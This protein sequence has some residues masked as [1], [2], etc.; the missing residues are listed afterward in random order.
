MHQSVSRSRSRAALATQGRGRTSSALGS[1]SRG[2]AAL[3]SRGR[4]RAGAALRSLIGALV[5]GLLKLLVLVAA[6][7]SAALLGPAFVLDTPQ[8]APTR[9]DAIVVISGD[10][11]MARFQEGLNLYQQGLGRYLVFS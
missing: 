5:R 6:L 1:P 8:A 2:R 10:E 4:G 7:A 3:P 9:S 11:Q